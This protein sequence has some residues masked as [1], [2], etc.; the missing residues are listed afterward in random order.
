LNIFLNRPT[1]LPRIIPAGLIVVVLIVIGIF[2][3]AL[4]Q[5]FQ[6]VASLMNGGFILVEPDLLILVSRRQLI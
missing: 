2:R 5:L 4:I 1:Q 3:D 6:R